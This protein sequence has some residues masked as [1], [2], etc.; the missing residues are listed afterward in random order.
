MVSCDKQ[1]VEILDQGNR[2][3]SRRRNA[4]ASLRR[5]AFSIRWNWNKDET[6]V[7]IR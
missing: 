4:N 1:R 2:G 3:V 6:I 7:F 5:T